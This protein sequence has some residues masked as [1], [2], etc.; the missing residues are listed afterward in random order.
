MTAKRV[1]LIL[2]ENLLK[3]HGINAP[4]IA[5][6]IAGEINSKYSLHDT[7][8]FKI[9]NLMRGYGVESITGS[10]VSHYW[11][12]INLLYVNMG[13]T[14]TPTVFYDTLK[15]KMFLGDWGSYVEK[16]PKRFK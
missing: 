5:K 2:G 10:Y 9:N 16:Y 14:Y 8:L 11:Q 3:E 1:L 6:S 4:T 15:D 12:D 13:D 7:K